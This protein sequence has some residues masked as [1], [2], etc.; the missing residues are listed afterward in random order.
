MGFSVAVVSS[1]EKRKFYCKNRKAR[2]IIYGQLEA[3]EQSSHMH[4]TDE[5]RSFPRSHDGASF[6]KIIVKAVVRQKCENIAQEFLKI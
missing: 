3:L 4:E 1:A 5:N 2:R 6:G